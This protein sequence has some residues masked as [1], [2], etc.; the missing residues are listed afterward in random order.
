MKRPYLRF[1]L[2]LTVSLALMWL[3]SQSMIEQLSH[4]HPTLANFYITLLMVSSMGIVMLLAMWHMY[5]NRRLNL[6][7]LGAF[8]AVFIG[9]FVLG[10]SATFIGDEAFLHS[11][12][13]HHS[14]AILLCQEA[15]LSDPQIIRLCD[16]I[17]E[18]QREEIRLM[19]QLLER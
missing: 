16:Q 12:I 2:T 5:G 4:F 19:E 10:R 13:P 8:A 7:L 17:I 6:V 18:T 1:G 15:E 14:R 9:A 11:M 3:I